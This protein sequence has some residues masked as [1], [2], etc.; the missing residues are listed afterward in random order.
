MKSPIIEFIV[1]VLLDA[2]YCL[3][4]KSLKILIDIPQKQNAIAVK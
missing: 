4:Q 1:E 3:M 2:D